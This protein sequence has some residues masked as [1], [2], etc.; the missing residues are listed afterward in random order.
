MFSQDW[1]GI[2]WKF[3]GKLKLKFT[4]ALNRSSILQRTKW[5]Y[6]NYRPMSLTDT[7]TPCWAYHIHCPSLPEPCMGLRSLCKTVGIGRLHGL[8]LAMAAESRVWLGGINGY[9]L[10]IL[11]GQLRL[12]IKLGIKKTEKA[13]RVTVSNDSCPTWE[14]IP[15][16]RFWKGL[17]KLLS[18]TRLLTA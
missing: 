8:I 13:Q 3:K 11:T 10:L 14:Y 15:K 16:V 2:K 5:G 18:G 7:W 17:T 6:R 9:N 4:K 1:P 12:Y